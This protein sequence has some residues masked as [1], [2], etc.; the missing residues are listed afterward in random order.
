MPK[1][2]NPTIDVP[3]PR[4]SRSK[5]HYLQALF[6]FLVFSVGIGETQV[7]FNPLS[8]FAFLAI[9]YLIRYI[10]KPIFSPKAWLTVKA[11]TYLALILSLGITPN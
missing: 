7:F 9:A 8:G 5:I 11:I 3:N 6:V 10:N 1:A 2:T 4:Q